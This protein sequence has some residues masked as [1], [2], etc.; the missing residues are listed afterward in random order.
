MNDII[1]KSFDQDVFN[2]RIIAKNLTKIIESKNKPM[3]I[4]LDSA[5]GTGKTTF[6]NMWKNML[7]TNAEYTTKFQP[8]YFN[9]M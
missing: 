7:D 2:R 8:L 4:S 1:L 5:W 3:V 6:I 9:S